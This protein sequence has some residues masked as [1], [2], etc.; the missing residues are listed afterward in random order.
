MLRFL[1]KD[2]GDYNK[3]DKHDCKVKS[4]NTEFRHGVESAERLFQN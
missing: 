4:R 1:Q 2:C 3:R